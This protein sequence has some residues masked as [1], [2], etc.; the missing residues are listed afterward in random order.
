MLTIA[1][2]CDVYLDPNLNKQMKQ[3]C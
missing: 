1:N 3:N 2:Q